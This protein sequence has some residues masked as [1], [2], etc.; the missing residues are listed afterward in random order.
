MSDTFPL[1]S[2]LLSDSGDFNGLWNTIISVCRQ[3]YDKWEMHLDRTR[4]TLKQ[5]LLISDLLGEN[6]NV[7]W[8]EDGSDW[9]IPSRAN[10]FVLPLLPG[11]I[12]EPTLL[13]D[14]STE[15]ESVSDISVV[16]GDEYSYNGTIINPVLYFKPDFSP[17]T[18]IC[19]NYIGRCAMTIDVFIQSGGLPAQFDEVDLWAVHLGFIKQDDI[20]VVHVETLAMHIRYRSED[21]LLTSGKRSIAMLN[22]KI[23][24]LGL[25]GTAYW[26]DWARR[27]AIQSFDIKFPDT[28]PTVGIII[29][30][31][32]NY[33]VLDVCIRSII[34]KTSYSNY[35]IFIVNNASDDADTVAY[36]QDIHQ[37]KC[38]VVHIPSPDSGFS[39]SYVN[40]EAVNKV[41]TTLI[42]FL[43]DDTE[44]VSESWLSQMVG[45]MG[46]NGVA[47][48]GAKLLFPD[49]LIQHAG[50][51]NNLLDGSLPAPAFKLQPNLLLGTM[52]Q[53]NTVRNYSALTAACLL[54]RREL[55][56]QSGG[57]DDE[58]FRVAYN[59]CDYG[60]RLT[61]LGMR[62][63]YVPSAVLY[64]YEGASRGRGAGNDKVE[65]ELNFIRKYSTWVDPYWN[66]NLSLDS[67]EFKPSTRRTSKYKSKPNNPTVALFTH[68]LNFEG[69]PLVL[70]D[71][72]KGLI[73][74]GNSSVIVISPQDGPLRKSYELIGAVVCVFDKA[75]LVSG[76]DVK[77]M[78]I[79]LKEISLCLKLYAV[80]V[81][82]ANTVLCHWGLFCGILAKLPTIWIIHES[83]PPFYHL[84]E[85][86]IFHVELARMLFQVNYVNVF[87]CYST[88]NVYDSIAKIDNRIVIYNGFDS[89]MTA[90]TYAQ[91]DRN[92]ERKLFGYD[93][94]FVFILP[95]TV[96]IRKSQVDLI[97]AIEM[98]NENIVSQ[99]QF[100]IVGD[101]DSPYSRELHAAIENLDDN[102]KSRVRV[103][104]ETSDIFRYYRMADGMIFTSRMESFPRVIQEAMF[105]SLPIIS[106]PVFGISEQL[107]DKQSALFFEPGNYKQL[108]ECIGE[109]VQ[110]EIKRTKM[111][112]LAHQSLSR[113]PSIV[114]MKLRYINLVEEAYA[115]SESE[116]KITAR[117]LIKSST[118]F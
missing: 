9:L 69:A 14:W 22:N 66:R 30:T 58:Q 45:W 118:L 60:F 44:V 83:E 102:R 21:L 57:F 92:K 31:K 32:N 79:N 20:S 51:V 6:K 65:E 93:K 56:V 89:K 54:T 67:F 97:F 23:I 71:I 72:S 86:G 55:F 33:K 107:R 41:D 26:P 13:E 103:V 40:N 38:K 87:V 91:F 98:L 76:S 88:K 35:S 1:F 52:S 63:V 28:G 70:Y 11:D 84:Q 108:C 50:L 78:E 48:T 59:D 17:E 8:L 4:L 7:I 39:Y 96:C 16:Y 24:D 111:A 46:R 114:D 25:N 62:H 116:K 2:V 68:N 37:Q 49:N 75:D 74:L 47:S 81:V 18:L 105:C 61:Q 85:W 27:S 82:I 110:N 64:H 112:E 36:L 94:D 117:S 115:A 10:S 3:T 73:E 77:Q 12:I 95:G 109:I 100:L 43:N 113:F 19:S 90:I 101:R 34:D 29:P 42:L 5:Q 106:T 53:D 80:D 15:I 99:T 104:L